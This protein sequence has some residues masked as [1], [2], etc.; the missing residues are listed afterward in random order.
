MVLKMAKTVV[1]SDELIVTLDKLRKSVTSSTGR[2]QSYDAVVRE[3]AGLA[4]IREPKA[5]KL[6]TRSKHGAHAQVWDLQVGGVYFMPWEWKA[7][8]LPGRDEATN[9]DGLRKALARCT[10][11]TGAQ[12][13][14]NGTAA[15]LNV[16]RMK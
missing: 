16:T 15:G 11:K 7:P 8:A 6:R 4:P 3:L 2:E 1:L 10:A 9:Y 13:W 14:E 5:P 12:F